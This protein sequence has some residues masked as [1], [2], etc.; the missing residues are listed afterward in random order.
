MAVPPPPAAG[1]PPA[2]IAE[3]LPRP[4]CPAAEPPPRRTAGRGR[5]A[6]PVDGPL[7][8]RASSGRPLAKSVPPRPA[9]GEIV[10]LRAGARSVG[11]GGEVFGARR[12]PVVGTEVGP[13][14]AE[15]SGGV[16]TPR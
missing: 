11:R 7:W 13:L 5:A 9:A 1:R 4:G 16:G 12:I 10:P 14:R 8:P 15:V 3:R 2:P 6:A